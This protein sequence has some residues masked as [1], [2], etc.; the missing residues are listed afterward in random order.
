MKTIS[1]R[2]WRRA[3][4]V[5][6]QAAAQFDHGHLVAEL[7]DPAHGFDQ[8]I[9]FRD[10]FLDHGSVALVVPEP[11]TDECCLARASAVTEEFRMTPL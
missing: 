6:Q 10:G 3:S 11:G 2:M 5:I 8:Y 9:R 1:I 4:G 7:A